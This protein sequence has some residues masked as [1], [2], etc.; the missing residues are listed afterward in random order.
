MIEEKTLSPEQR[1]YGSFL[2]DY[3]NITENISSFKRDKE[4]KELKNRSYS[5]LKCNKFLK[6]I[7]FSKIK[8]VYTCDCKKDAETIYIKDLVH[9]ELGEKEASY[10]TCQKHNNKKFEFYCFD[11][12]E[13]LCSEC[14]LLGHKH[15]NIENLNDIQNIEEKIEKLNEIIQRYNYN[16]IDMQYNSNNLDSSFDDYDEFLFLLKENED[17]F[18]TFCIVTINY[19]KDYSTYSQIENLNKI[20]EYVFSLKII[21]FIKYQTYY[22]LRIYIFWMIL[23]LKI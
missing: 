14:K 9:H 6:I 13:N 18:I 1:L 21:C 10:L 15:N 5:C 20:Y 2:D 12:E 16:Q 11:C 22:L 7:I 23:M 17:K 3:N 4:I 19:F 8:I